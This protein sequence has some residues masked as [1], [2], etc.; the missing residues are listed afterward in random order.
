M[1]GRKASKKPMTIINPEALEICDDPLPTARAMPDGKY[2]AS[3]P[4]WPTAMPQMPARRSAQ[5]SHRPEKWLDVNKKP[6]SVRSTLR[7]ADDGTG[8]VWLQ[9]QNPRR[10][11]EQPTDPCHWRPEKLF[12][13]RWL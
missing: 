13:L 11:R 6:G 3:S 8:R 9:P 2:S 7:Y 5:D 12:T 4:R 10:S 1:D